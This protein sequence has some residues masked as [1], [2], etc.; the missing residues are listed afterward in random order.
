[1]SDIHKQANLVDLADTELKEFLGHAYHAIKNLEEEKKNDPDIQQMKEKLTLY[2]RDNYDDS[3]KELKAR[4][5]AARALAK[6]R[7]VSWT[8]PEV[9]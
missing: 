7:G 4:M 6:A 5:K 2:T 9:Q 8:P 3:L 1:M